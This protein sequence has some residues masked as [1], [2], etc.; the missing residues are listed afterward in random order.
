MSKEMFKN[1]CVDYILEHEQED[2]IEYLDSGD[3]NLTE[4]EIKKIKESVIYERT[5]SKECINLMKSLAR[6]H[7]Y[8]TAWSA[9]FS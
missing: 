9:R 1:D 2:F 5:P 3:S 4:E 7:I 6:Y 8:A